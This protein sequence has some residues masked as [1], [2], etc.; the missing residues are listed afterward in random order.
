MEPITIDQCTEL[1]LD[2]VSI[3]P[4]N[5]HGLDT[6]YMVHIQRCKPRYIDLYWTKYDTWVMTIF[7]QYR[8]EDSGEW[9]TDGAVYDQDH[10]YLSVYMVSAKEPSVAEFIAH[11]SNEIN[12]IKSMDCCRNLSKG[13]IQPIDVFNYAQQVNKDKDHYL[14]TTKAFLAVY[15]EWLERLY[16]TCKLASYM[17]KHHDYQVTF[18]P[19][20]FD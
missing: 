10:Y 8:C 18:S 16:N 12:I 5:H 1:S 4:Y 20:F 3:K 13:D 19:Y 2:S 15:D 11:L 9:V 6:R 7:S 14:R 17:S